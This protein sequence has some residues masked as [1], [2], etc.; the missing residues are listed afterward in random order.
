MEAR[1]GEIAFDQ[2]GEIFSPT[3]SPDGRAAAFSALTGGSSDLYIYGLESGTLRQITKDLFAD[4]QPAWSP[5]GRTIAFV[6]N[7]FSTRLG[8]LDFGNYRLPLFDV[9]SRQIREKTPSN[10]ASRITTA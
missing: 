2:S 4:L 5:D 6:T 10:T 7:R 3:W 8:T 1:P 9:S